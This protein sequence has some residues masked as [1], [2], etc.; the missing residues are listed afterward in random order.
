MNKKLEFC[1]FIETHN[2]QIALLSETFLKE[3]HKFN[4]RNY[5][6]YRRD[7]VDGPKGG[8]AIIVHKS[9]SH[10]QI[11]LPNLP[12]FQECMAIKVFCDGED[13]IIVSVYVP[14][15]VKSI[16]YND[17]SG[18]LGIGSRVLLAGDFNARH[19]HW[20]CKNNNARGK[21]IFD[22]YTRNMD[23]IKIHFPDM[24]TYFPEDPNRSPSTIDLCLS[25]NI[26]LGSRPLSISEMSS[27]H[28]PIIIEIPDYTTTLNSEKMIFDYNKADWNM[29]RDI[30]DEQLDHAAGF[31]TNADI[32]L[33]IEKLTNAIGLAMERAVPKKRPFSQDFPEFLKELIRVKNGIRRFWQQNDR[34]REFKK[35]LNGLIGHISYMTKQWRNEITRK[36]L[37]GIQPKENRLFDTINKFT[38]NRTKIPPL[39]ESDNTVIYSEKGKAERIAQH[40]EKV[41]TQNDSMGTPRHNERVNKTVTEYLQRTEILPATVKL[42]RPSEL[43]VYIKSLRTK[44]SPG[45]DKITN[46]VIKNFSTK[47]IIL[48]TRIINAIMLRGYFP[49]A[50]KM[51]VVIPV[52]KPGKPPDRPSNLRPISL[53]SSLSKITEK[54]ILSRI[55]SHITDLDLLP[56]EQF[57]FRQSHSTTHAL[58]RITR[59]IGSRLKQKE[60][61]TMV[62]LDIEKAFDTVWFNGLIYK[63]IKYDFPPYIVLLIASYLYNRGFKVLV[64]ETF[65][66]IKQISAGVPQ[67][68]ILG[69]ILFILFIS[70]IP[71]HPKTDFSVFADDTA[72]YSS[73]LSIPQNMRYLQQHLDKLN[74]YYDKWKI[75]INPNKTESITFTNRRKIDT[76]SLTLKY[77]DTPI[78]T[79]DCI[80][81][82]GI[83]FQKNLKFNNHVFKTAQKAGMAMRKLFTFI[84][85]NSYL[86]SENKL[87]IYKLFI[88][89]LLTHNIQVW[90]TISKTSLNKLQVIQNKNLRMAYNLQPDPFTHKHIM[91]NNDLHKYKKSIP[92]I[93]QFA[94][95]LSIKTFEKM[96]FSENSLIKEMSQ[97]D[98]SN[99]DKKSPFYIL[100]DFN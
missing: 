71:E 55:N 43:R 49:Q 80:R 57:G 58:L 11:A 97:I 6:I 27:D 33:A 29:F 88:R 63:L 3:K 100:R 16:Q 86:K 28:N 2:I 98:I 64:E 22:Y 4:F 90:N 72:I 7:R 51:A 69:P 41:H 9:I 8:N 36:D 18:I 84:K 78:K 74:I 94:K 99:T 13:M 10:E 19:T 50:W 26:E 87:T 37:M 76:G 68:S 34:P 61:T 53:L 95:S 83:Y 81:Y 47:T 92:T 66:T 73:S 1:D 44:K 82:L 17:L 21:N 24:H 79:V 65:S 70:D 25:K 46:R 67:G 52:P 30:M 89:P 93:K 48:F 31:R 54:V 42:V 38:H 39:V 23:R 62:V 96:K 77:D 59:H 56:N 32:D 60:S 75:K 35:I 40:F 5:K 15:T 91:S 85:Y 14:N 45:H 12:A 20:F